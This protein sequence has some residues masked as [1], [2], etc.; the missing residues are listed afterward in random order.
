M[1]RSLPWRPRGI[2][3]KL[4]VQIEPTRGLSSA[5]AGWPALASFG[6]RAF[7]KFKFFFLTPT[8]H[9]SW[10][11]VQA[12][13][14]RP[15]R[16]NKAIKAGKVPI[17][18]IELQ[19]FIAARVDLQPSC[20]HIASKIIFEIYLFIYEN[21]YSGHI[22][23]KSIIIS[24]YKIIPCWHSYCLKFPSVFITSYG[25]SHQNR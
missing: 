24:C 5:P 16:P 9:P 4:P 3:C 13:C 25:S 18:G 22:S 14:G 7:P 19:A 10:L 2:V 1:P 21:K 6:C 23:L 12:R 15:G 11:M 8:R 17:P 20:T